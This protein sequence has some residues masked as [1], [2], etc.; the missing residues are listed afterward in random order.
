MAQSSKSVKK[1]LVRNVEIPCSYNV[2]QRPVAINSLSKN[3]YTH[4]GPITVPKIKQQME[5]IRKAEVPHSSNV[6]ELTPNAVNF[7]QTMVIHLTL[8]NIYIL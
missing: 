2:L 6:N 3:R 8:N 4:P 5:R 1:T 7:V